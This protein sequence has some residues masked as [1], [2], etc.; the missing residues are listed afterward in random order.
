MIRASVTAKVVILI[1]LILFPILTACSEPTT[2]APMA[3]IAPTATSTAMPEPPPIPTDTP[4]PEP[5]ATE[6]PPTEVPVMSE[7]VDVGGYEVYVKC[8]GEGSPTVVLVS[9]HGQDHAFWTE[10]TANMNAD[11]GVRICTYDRAGLGESDPL[12]TEPRTNQAMSDE[13]RAL[14]INA[15]I[16]GPYILAG[17]YGGHSITRIFADQYPDDVAGMILIGSGFEV[18]VHNL[19][20]ETLPPE[21]EGEDPTITTIRGAFSFCLGD[22]MQQG[23]QFDLMTSLGQVEA[24]D[25]LGDIPLMVIANDIIDMQPAVNDWPNFFGGAEFTEEVL[26]DI[27]EDRAL[28]YLDLTGLSTDSELIVIRGCNFNIVGGYPDAIAEAIED[29]VEKVR[30][31]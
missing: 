16:P 9:S 22:P 13:L 28:Q 21:E 31:Q 5:T 20:T 30:N 2:P 1:A 14:L 3:T 19:L 12:P 29:M 8:V 25:S 10:I 6:V 4:E 11:L 26:F 7:M 15:D 27:E 17:V 24:V 23:E 18:F